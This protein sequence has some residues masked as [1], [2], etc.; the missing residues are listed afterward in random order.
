MTIKVKKSNVRHNGT[1]YTIGEMITGLSEQEEVRLI[2]LGVAEQIEVIFEKVEDN[3]PDLKK[4]QQTTEQEKQNSISDE[5]QK[6]TSDDNQ[7]QNDTA[8]NFNPDE[9]IK[10]TKKSRKSK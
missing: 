9:V 4:E 6:S 3:P 2:S 1:S 5:V 7:R 10:K 8:I